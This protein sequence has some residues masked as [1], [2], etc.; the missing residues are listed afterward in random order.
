[1]TTFDPFASPGLRSRNDGIVT[2]PGAAPGFMS[3][4]VARGVVIVAACVTGVAARRAVSALGTVTAGACVAAAAVLAGAAVLIAALSVRV[5]GV[6]ADL[7]EKIRG[8]RTMTSAIKA[9]ASSVRLSMR[10]F[11]QS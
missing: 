8:V 10:C 11:E 9:A 2:S 1:M 5:A 6:G 4:N 7:D 3:A